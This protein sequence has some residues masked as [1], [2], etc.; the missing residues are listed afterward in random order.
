MEW[1]WRASPGTWLAEI[2]FGQ[3]VS[4]LGYL[5]NI[6]VAS[7]A[8]GFHLDWKWLN[9]GVLMAIGTIYRV[10]AFVGMG[11]AFRLRR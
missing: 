5:Y 11:V 3:L 2:Y 1:L 9:I 4:P 8:T 7:E 6:E 10:L